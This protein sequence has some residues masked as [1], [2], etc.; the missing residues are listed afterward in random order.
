MSLPV[1]FRSPASKMQT[2]AD[3]SQ[4]EVS[5]LESCCS[6]SSAH[7]CAHTEAPK[8]GLL[9][10]LATSNFKRSLGMGGGPCRAT[11]AALLRKCERLQIG[12]SQKGL[13]WKALAQTHLP[14]AL[15]AQSHRVE[16][17]ACLATSKFKRSLGMVGVPTRLLSQPCSEDPNVCR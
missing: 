5:I 10:C 7:G 15:L 2:S 17:H 3:R 4:P 1:S 8:L 13:P 6:D 14:M 12:G 11:F 16:L 9:A